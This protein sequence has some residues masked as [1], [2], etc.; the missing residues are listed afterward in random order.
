MRFPVKLNR[1]FW[2]RFFHKITPSTNDPRML[3]HENADELIFTQSVSVFLFGTTY[4]TT[5]KD[6]FPLT[7]SEL[8][9]LKFQTPPVIL[10][11]GASD[12][13]TSLDVLKAVPFERYYVTD[14]NTD[15]FYK[16]IGSVAWFFD[17]SGNCILRV[18]DKLIMYTEIV[19]AI[20]PFNK[21]SQMAFKKAPEFKNDMPRIRLI[22]P[23]LL[24]LKD[25]RV[26]VE[27]YD[28]F[29]VWPFEKVDLIVSANILNR[30]YFSDSKLEYALKELVAALKADGR[31]TIID[32]R[33]IEKATIF[34][35]FPG[36]S[37]QVEKRINGGTEI[38]D[39]AL[40]V[41]TKYCHNC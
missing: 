41:F 11:V 37:C 6:R 30:A 38:E 2:P 3:F 40:K 8:G 32:N 5:K 16:V 12:G 26:V 25:R 4:K 1:A 7:I 17:V 31:I 22:N 29:N 21:I 13:S 33:D 10:D 34:R 20:F 23:R 28:M 24:N 18:S 9:R 19:N 36:S 27:K 15:V 14:L 35:F 39:L